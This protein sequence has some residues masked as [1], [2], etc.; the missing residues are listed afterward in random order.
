MGYVYRHI[1]LDKNEPFYIGIGG[2]DK[3]D[4]EYKRAFDKTRRN[5]IWLKI[6][7]KTD[8]RVEI[9]LDDL[10]FDECC[11]KEIEL[12]KLYGRIDL[13][14]GTLANMT[15]GGESGYGRVVSDIT[16]EKLRNRIV[17]EKMY[18]SLNR[19]DKRHSEFSKE[20]MRN[21]IHGSA[22]KSI[23]INID[24]VIYKSYNQASR[25]LDIPLTTL[26]RKF[27]KK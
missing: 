22:K 19:K 5:N 25:M 16:K 2:F 23:E 7:N 4:D 14:T 8:Y 12:I 20:K 6:T 3:T 21:N 15:N 13:K 27:I 9:L 1:R 26:Y 10:L 17:T 18:N 24:G 11:I